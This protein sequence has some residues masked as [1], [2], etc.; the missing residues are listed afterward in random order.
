MATCSA[1]ALDY[2]VRGI[3]R[4]EE[5]EHCGLPGHNVVQHPARARCHLGLGRAK[6]GK[7]SHLC[8]AAAGELA[9][10]S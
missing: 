3:G 8:P 7:L 9:I 1:C 5:G 4:I 6:R 2:E 10:F